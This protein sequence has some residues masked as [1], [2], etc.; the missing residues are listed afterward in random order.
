[1]NHALA[2]ESCM[3]FFCDRERESASYY[4]PCEDC[5]QVMSKGIPLFAVEFVRTNEGDPAITEIDGRPM[6]PT[7]AWVVVPQEAIESLITP[8]ERAQLVIEKGKAFVHPSIIAYFD[9]FVEVSDGK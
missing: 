7:G 6:Y 1:M 3:C 9:Q 4:E 5:Q 2:T 8:L